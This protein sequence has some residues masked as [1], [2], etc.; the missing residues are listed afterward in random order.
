VK[1]PETPDTV[2]AAAKAMWAKIKGERN[3][4]QSVFCISW[5]FNR[6]QFFYFWQQ[7]CSFPPGQYPRDSIKLG[8]MK[9]KSSFW[10]GSP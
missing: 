4:R 3:S 8:R 5:S 10:F 1:K 7:N 6:L 9:N 2:R